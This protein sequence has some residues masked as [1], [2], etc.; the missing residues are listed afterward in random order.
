[1]KQVIDE[2]VPYNYL[3]SRMRTGLESVGLTWF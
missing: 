2:F 3:P 1:M